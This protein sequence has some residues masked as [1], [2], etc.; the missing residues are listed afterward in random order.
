MEKG[1]SGAFR[2]LI[3]VPEPSLDLALAALHIARDEYPTLSIPKYIK[4]LDALSAGARRVLGRVRSGRA[5]VEGLNHYLFEQEGFCGNTAD[6]YDPRNSLLN[7]VLER[8]TGIPITLSLVYMEVGRRLDYP[9]EGVGLPG[10]FIVRSVRDQSLFMDP[11]NRGEILDRED[12]IRKVQSLVGGAVE[13][14]DS[15][16][17]PASKLQIIRRML[18]N[19]KSIYLKQEAYAKALPVIEKILA[20]DPESRQEMRDRALVLLRLSRYAEARAQLAACADGNAMGS[21]EL[22]E[23]V[24]ELLTWVRQLN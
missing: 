20:V 15:L 10:H 17:E 12:C 3:R 2:D 14:E 8:R 1:S 22:K 23:E 21:E 19:L 9:I 18:N 7:D 13:D 5:L 16:L 11:F 6:Y 24:Q 4:Q